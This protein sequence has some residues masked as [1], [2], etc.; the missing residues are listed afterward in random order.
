MGRLI[1]YLPDNECNPLLSPR[2][3]AQMMS[4]VIESGI[5]YK[6]IRSGYKVWK[7]RAFSRSTVPNSKIGALNDASKTAFEATK[8]HI[9]IWAQKYKYLLGT[10]ARKSAQ[11]NTA[12]IE[13]VRGLVK[14]ALTSPNAKFMVN[15]EDNS[16]RVVADMGRVI[17]TK[18]QTA[19]R[20]SIGSDGKIWNA[21]PVNHQ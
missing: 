2:N 17:G 18:K 4:Y 19:I 6:G 8:N 9:N 1:S 11:F 7:G 16:F 10:T 3:W 13:N 21:F 5:T 15:N 12:N 14:E 20:I